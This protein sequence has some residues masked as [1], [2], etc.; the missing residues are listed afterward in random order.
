ME[1]PAPAA[2]IETAAPETER[3]TLHADADPGDGVDA[4][5]VRAWLERCG[6]SAYEASRRTGISESTL[7]RWI[8]GLGAR[9][10][11]EFAR[12]MIAVVDQLGAAEVERWTRKRTNLRAMRA[13][14]W[15]QGSQGRAA[16]ILG[17]SQSQVS[18]WAD[19][20]REV[21]RAIARLIEL[22]DRL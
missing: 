15:A 3:L 13:W 5:E 1:F 22:L 17:V 14:V 9:D 16:A 10:I 2:V 20:S 8:R 11:P 7:S 19:G 21:P 6:W 4:A 12:R 18:R